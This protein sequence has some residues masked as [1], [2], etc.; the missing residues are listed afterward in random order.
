M[1]DAN[2]IIHK[3]FIFISESN[4]AIF[5]FPRALYQQASAN[6]Y[7]TKHRLIIF[8]LKE[9]NRVN[10]ASGCLNI[11]SLSKDFVSRFLFL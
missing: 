7:L 11:T 4:L 9:M 10:A 8:S 3:P 2:F 6:L 1:I 5:W